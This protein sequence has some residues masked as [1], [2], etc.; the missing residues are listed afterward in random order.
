MLFNNYYNNYCNNNP[1]VHPYMSKRTLLSCV[2]KNERENDLKNRTLHY[3]NKITICQDTFQAAF[4]LIFICENQLEE[5]WN[6]LAIVN[7]SQ[8]TS[9]HL[10]FRLNVALSLSRNSWKC[11]IVD[12]KSVKVLVR[13]SDFWD[14]RVCCWIT[15]YSW[16]MLAENKKTKK[17][18]ED[19]R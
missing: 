6:L 14:L 8:S 11:G 9:C 13:S 1:A 3:Y 4:S 17:Q 16:T 15:S 2:I 18:M 7:P 10:T 12:L 5:I 19:R